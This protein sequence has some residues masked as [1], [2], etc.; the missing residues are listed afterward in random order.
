MHLGSGGGG[1]YHR[2]YAAGAGGSGGGIIFITAPYLAV[3]A[4]T[5]YVTSNGGHGY[6]GSNTGDGDAHGGGGSGGSILIRGRDISLGSGRVTASGGTSYPLSIS[7]SGGDGRIRIESCHSNPVSGSTSPAAITASIDCYVAEQVA[8]DPYTT[9]RL[10]LPDSFTGGQTY[11]IQYGR[12]FAFSGAAS[13][14]SYLRVNRRMYGSASLDVLVSNTGVA[15]GDLDLC[16]DI[17]NDGTCNYHPTGTQ[18]FP[19]TLSTAG[20]AS[21]FNAY[22]TGRNDVA[23]GDPVDVPVRVQVDR[24]ADVM[25]TNLALTPVGAKTRFLRLPAQNYDQVTLD[26]RFGL[27]TTPDG[28]LSYTVDVGADGSVDWT[29]SGSANFPVV[30]TSPNLAAAFNAYLAGKSGDVDVPIRITPSPSVETALDHFSTQPTARPD[31]SIA[32]GDITFDAANPTEGDPVTVTALLHNGGSGN[33]GRLTAS[34]YAINPDWGEWYIGSAFVPDVPVGGTAQASII[35]NTLGFT[36]TVPVRVTVDPYNR[37]AETNETNNTASTN[38][39]IKTRP[40]L[41]VESI[42]L[43]DAEPMAGETI[44]ATIAVRNGGQTATGASRVA[45]Y[46]GNPDKGGLLLG[47]STLPV[48]AGADAPVN[49]T[50]KPAAAGPHQLFAR[51]DADRVVNE[52]DEAN[53]D[54]W[55]DVYVGF[56]SPLLIDSGGGASFDPAYTPELGFGYL[57]GEDS[58]FCGSDVTNSA[59]KDYSAAVRYRFDHLL[60][61]HFYHL[62]L[63]LYECND[64]G[65]RL[66]QVRVDDNVISDQIDL[67]DGTLHRLSFRLDPAFYADRGITVSI[68]ELNGGDAIVSEIN[69]YDIDYRYADAGALNEPA[70]SVGRGYGPLDG[71]IQSPPPWGTLPYQTRRIDGSDSDPSDDPDNELRYRYDHLDKNKKYQLWLKLYQGAG[72]ATIKENISVDTVDTGQVLQVVGVAQDEKIVDVPVGMYSTDGTI[73]VRIVRQGATAN[74]WIN[75]IALEE[76]TLTQPPCSEVA[77]K[78]VIPLHSSATGPNWFSFNI[79]PPVQPPAACSG[80]SPTSLFTTLYGQPLLAGAP[81]PVGSIIEAFTPGGVKTGCFKVTE[82]G[83]YGYMRVY[84]AE[85]STPGMAAGDPIIV[86]VNGI[87]ATTAP[88]PLVWQDDKATREVNLDAPDVVPIET[89]LNPLGGK[90]TKLQCENGT[91]LPPPADPRFNT[92]TTVAAGGSYLLWMNTAANLTVSGCPVAQDKPVALHVGYNWLGYLPTCELTVASALQTIQGKYDIVHSEAGTYKPPPANPGLN[93]FNTLAP[94]RGYMIHMTQAATLTFPANLCGGAL[95]T[96][97]VA[98]PAAIGCAAQPTSRFTH[99]FGRVDAPAG[100]EVLAYSPR[101]EVV[102]CGRVAEDG[103]LPYLRVY[104]AEGAAPGMQ[105]GE[106]ISFTVAGQ[107]LDAQPAWQNDW[108]VHRLGQPENDSRTYLPLL[109]R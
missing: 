70:Y 12:R 81:A 84:G 3:S 11:L 28:P 50:W 9:T 73:T 72:T 46:D 45:L 90:V 23:W 63:V 92:C 100:S 85:G 21:A 33:T 41:R 96:D 38:K 57:G 99:Y 40:D 103:L 20:L 39:V 83:L 86:K 105:D 54:S 71:V 101:G 37:I 52:S 61:G 2:Q 102:G 4:S 88:Y 68:E 1:A 108:N 76:L 69:L 13:Q 74:A 30:V 75:E 34:F 56:A 7:N 59:R 48:A 79:K 32:A 97:V 44:T 94:G 14:P 104:G 31:A 19:L 89:L 26:V 49:V 27:E 60:P 5:G 109:M 95:K 51:V 107:T 98:E 106:P 55:R 29:G 25:L 22:L 10:F 6:A 58:T 42:A 15:S 36:G 66:E 87:A 64:G 91:Y 82:A 8:S 93:N 16:L 24:K 67:S 78:Q 47:D 53:N 35:W 77:V 62:D 18:T 80:V 17:G 65:G 43:S